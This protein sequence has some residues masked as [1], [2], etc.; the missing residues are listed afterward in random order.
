MNPPTPLTLLTIGGSDSGGAAG[1]QADL[2]AWAQLGAYGLSAVTMVTAQNSVA[3]AAA[4]YLPPALLRA[5]LDAVLNDYGAAGIKT[6]FIGRTP[7]IATIARRLKG[8]NCPVV[9]DPV[10]VNHRREQMFPAT[11]TAAYCKWLLPLAT[12]LTPNQHEAALLIG[13]PIHTREDAETAAQALHQLGP[14]N[15]LIKGLPHEDGLLDLLFDGR[16]FTPFTHP[17]VPTANTHGSGDTL[18]A[19]LC[20]RLASGADMVTA[21]QDAVRFTSAAIQQGAGWELGAGHGPVGW[22][23]V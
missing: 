4:H 21:V 12:L 16:S 22:G 17:A 23:T 19:V 15:V 2:R 1:I 6:G 18:S 14:R 10:L 5:Q 8:V 3:V 7:L 11:V 20:A 13:Q 9:V